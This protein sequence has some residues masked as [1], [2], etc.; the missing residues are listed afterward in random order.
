VS[1]SIADKIKDIKI[2]SN[3][4]GSDHCPIGLEIDFE[5]TP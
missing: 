1:E 5:S 2:Y 3:I 4:I